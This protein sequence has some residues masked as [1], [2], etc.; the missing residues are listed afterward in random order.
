VSHPI[1]ASGLCRRSWGANIDSMVLAGARTTWNPR[2]AQRVLASG[3]VRGAEGDPSPW[4]T[5]RRNGGVLFLAR[6]VGRHN[7]PTSRNTPRCSH[8]SPRNKRRARRGLLDYIAV[9]AKQEPSAAVASPQRL[10][11]T[12][13]TNRELGW[14]ESRELKRRSIGALVFFW[15]GGRRAKGYHRPALRQ[16]ANQLARRGIGRLCPRIESC[17]KRL[18]TPNR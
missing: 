2:Q 13:F 8:R 5:E 11:R 17:G 18:R 9:R 10:I 16:L 14:A 4:R 15:V 1:L 12:L 6:D 7:H 3:E